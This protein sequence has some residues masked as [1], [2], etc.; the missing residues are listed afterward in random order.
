MNR[1]TVGFDRVVTLLVGLGLV[2]AGLAAIAWRSGA[3]GAGRSLSVPTDVMS[4]SWWPWAVG[5]AG[6]VLILLA[7]RW[8]AAHRWAPRASRVTLTGDA[9]ATADATS[10]ASAAADT[11]GA[12]PA[13]TKASGSAALLQGRPTLTLTARVPA[14]NGLAAAVTA[15]DEAARTAAVMLGDSVAVRTVLGVDP[16]A[17]AVVR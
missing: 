5:G 10:V 8:L 15:A 13:V 2:A 17:G 7:L 12:D 4:A 1:K 9:A 6:A 3:L 16:K 11:L 14:R